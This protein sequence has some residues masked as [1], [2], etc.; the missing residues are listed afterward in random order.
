MSAARPLV[1]LALSIYVA[2][3]QV[4]AVAAYDV[5]QAFTPDA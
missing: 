2:G 1:L 3:T 4:G 5:V